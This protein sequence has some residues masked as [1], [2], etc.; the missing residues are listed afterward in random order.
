MCG[1]IRAN[2]DVLEGT[3][4]LAFNENRRQECQ[5]HS[6]ARRPTARFSLRKHNLRS[7]ETLWQ[8]FVVVIRAVLFTLLCQFGRYIFY[9]VSGVVSKEW[10]ICWMSVRN[11]WETDY[12]KVVSN[13]LNDSTE[14]IMDKENKALILDVSSG[15]GMNIFCNALTDIST[16]ITVLLLLIP[17]VI[18]I[19]II[20]NAMYLQPY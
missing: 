11:Q 4:T 2:L 19:I 1:G 8:M 18:I 14:S 7:L 17:L 16:T 9:F 20:I 3:E 10:V 12:L 5:A 6:L 15:W 13:R